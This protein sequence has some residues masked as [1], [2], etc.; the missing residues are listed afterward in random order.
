M[1]AQYKSTGQN[2]LETG[3]LWPSGLNHLILSISVNVTFTCHRL[4]STWKYQ[5]RSNP[6]PPSAHFS[7]RMG[8]N[9]GE[10]HVSTWGSKHSHGFYLSNWGAGGV[11]GL[12][13]PLWVL[14]TQPPTHAWGRDEKRNV[15]L[16]PVTATWGFI[17]SLSVSV[18]VWK[19][20]L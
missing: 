17:I 8:Q 20:P 4:S 15:M 12:A 6:R 10:P 7:L 11:T 1:F 9:M 16:K 2:S 13:L 19:S 18:L 3:P 14:P 5:D